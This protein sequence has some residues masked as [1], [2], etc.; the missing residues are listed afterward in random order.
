MVR[1]SAAIA[2]SRGR[3]AASFMAMRWSRDETR[4]ATS[5]S[6]VVVPASRRSSYR[7]APVASPR[8]SSDPNRVSNVSAQRLGVELERTSSRGSA[9]TRSELGERRSK[10]AEVLTRSFVR[11]VDV[12]G[13]VGR[14]VRD[15]REAT[16]DDEVDAVPNECFE[17]RFRVETVFRRVGQRLGSPSCGESG[18]LPGVGALPGAVRVEPGS[19]SC[20]TPSRP[21]QRRARAARS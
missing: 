17:D 20:R 6:S 1:Y 8:T 7:G 18:R 13:V 11:H 16:D 2:R 3:P 10:P 14:P 9:E 4:T 15:A 12:L 5:H 21:G 19:V